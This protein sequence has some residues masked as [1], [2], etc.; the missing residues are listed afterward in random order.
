MD[1]IGALGSGSFHSLQF[2]GDMKAVWNIAIHPGEESS[3]AGSV[4]TANSSVKSEV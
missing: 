4:E 2:W 3:R 1:V